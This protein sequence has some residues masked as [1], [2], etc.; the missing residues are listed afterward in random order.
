MDLSIGICLSIFFGQSNGIQD[1]CYMFSKRTDA[2]KT[3]VNVYLLLSFEPLYLGEK[4]PRDIPKLPPALLTHRNV[5]HNK[6]VMSFMTNLLRKG[7][8][9]RSSDNG[10]FLLHVYC[11]CSDTY[12]EPGIKTDQEKAVDIATTFQHDIVI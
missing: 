5:I 6:M 8:S 11:F 4:P 9:Q 12:L 1:S 2:S 7:T 3:S 10:F